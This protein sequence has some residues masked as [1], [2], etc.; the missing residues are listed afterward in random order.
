MPKKVCTDTNRF[1]PSS[2]QS[3]DAWAHPDAE[4]I[5][6]E[7]RDYDRAGQKALMRCRVCGHVFEELIP[8]GSPRF[9]D[10]I[11]IRA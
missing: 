6:E 3:G 9:V 5:G 10:T 2:G 7:G 1:R 4:E 11:T 8:Y